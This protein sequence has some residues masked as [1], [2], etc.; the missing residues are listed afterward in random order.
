VTSRVGFRAR[1]IVD[2][3][4][5]AQRSRDRTTRRRAIARRVARITR[6]RAIA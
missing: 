6:R 1:S 5:R 4:I 2:E 3:V